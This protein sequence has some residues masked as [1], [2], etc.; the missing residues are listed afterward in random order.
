MEYKIRYLSQFF[1]QIVTKRTEVH[2]ATKVETNK[3]KNEVTVIPI[4]R[5]G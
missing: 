4:W 2:V 1:V 5:L 3:P